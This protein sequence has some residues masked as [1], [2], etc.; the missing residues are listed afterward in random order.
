MLAVRILEIPC[1][2]PLNTRFFAWE[3]ATVERKG[4]VARV[5]GQVDQGAW[6]KAGWRTR[7]RC[8]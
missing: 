7:S 3:L 5:G 4:A 8:G 6:R 1:A 2:G